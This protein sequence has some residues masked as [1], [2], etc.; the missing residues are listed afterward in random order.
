MQPKSQAPP[1]NPFTGRWQS[2]GGDLATFTISGADSQGKAIQVTRTLDATRHDSVQSFHHSMAE[3]FG[4]MPA[5]DRCP[6]SL[7]PSSSPEPSCLI[8]RNLDPRILYGYGDPCVLPPHRDCGVDQYHVIVTSNDAPDKFP[9]LS[10]PD[11]R[12]WELAGFAFPQGSKPVWAAEGANQSDYWAPEIH[13]VGGDY[14]LCFAARALKGGMAIGLGRAAHPRGPFEV[15]DDPLISDNVIDPHIFVDRDGTTYLF[16]KQDNN[17]AWPLRLVRA[18]AAEPRML[19]RLFAAEEDQRTLYLAL[20]LLPWIEQQPSMSRFFALQPVI[21]LVTGRYAEIRTALV[22]I[23]ADLEP[24]AAEE[25][26]EITGLMSTPVFVQQLDT[27][28]L[29][30]VG[31]R[32]V[33]LR[34]DQDWEAHLIEGAWV[35]C[36]SGRYYLFYSGNDFST[37]EYGIGVAVADSPLGPFRKA[38]APFLLSTERWIGPGHPSVAVGHDGEPVL[39][40]HA[41]KPGHTG[42]KAFRVLLSLPLVFTPD[43]VE[44]RRAT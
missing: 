18:I 30:L 26:Q 21:E 5:R 3:A 4:L 24:A 15:P 40:F 32:R 36:H 8:D 35:R 29:T 33:A 11:L 37:S 44:S 7:P 2:S 1:P 22:A 31:D 14:L 23:A 19:P 9:I 16:W 42:Y 13:R 38:P 17:D 12:T 6:A 20:A 41:Y 25:V 39:F 34:N 27:E 43:G 28:R 10:S